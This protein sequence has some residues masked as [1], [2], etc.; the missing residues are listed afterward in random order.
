MAGRQSRSGKRGAGRAKVGRRPTPGR[1][2]GEIEIATAKLLLEPW[3]WLTNPQFSGLEHVAADRPALYV[4]NHTLMGVLDV[5]LLVLD[6]Y[7][8]KGV[9]LR[10]LGDHLHFTVPLWRDLL[11]RFGAIDGTRDNCRALMRS[12][13]SILVFPGG[14]REVFKRKGEQYSLIWKERM[15]FARLAIEFGYPIVPLAAVGAEECYDILFDHDDFE[16]LPLWPVI[17]RLVPRADEIPPVVRGL[18]PLPRPQRFYFHFGKPVETAAVKGQQRDDAVC[19]AV[20]EKV[21][22][23]VAANLRRLL[24]QRAADQQ[25]DLA[26]RLRQRAR[27]Q[28]GR[29]AAP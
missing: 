12:G 9:F 2:P 17:E 25:A 13:E 21:R 23:A 8:R 11:S 15:G 28:V 7:E 3:Q 29:K 20:R 5:P 26:T 19:F 10:A 22:R 24:A 6:L 4:A 27:R 1:R 14:G 16:K 18:G